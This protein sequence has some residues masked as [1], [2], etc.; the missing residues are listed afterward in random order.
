MTTRP[1]MGEREIDDFLLW[2]RVERG[3]S[4]STITSYHRDLMKYLVWLNQEGTSV[5]AVE[6]ESII[7]YLRRLQAEG[8]AASTVTRAMVAI[9]AFHRFLTM[10]SIRADDPTSDVELPRVPRGLPKPI[11]EKEVIRLLAAIEGHEPAARRDR[12]ILELLYGTGARISEVVTLSIS[13]VDIQESLLKVF[14]KGKKERI[15]P[16][17]RCALEAINEWLR[18]EGRGAFE[19][20]LWACRADSEA[21][22]L[23]RRGHRLSRQGGWGIVKKYGSRVGLGSGLSPHTLRHSCATHM[24]EHGADIRTVQELLGHASISTTQIYTQVSR[25]QLIDAYRSAHPRALI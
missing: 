16:L 3:R 22:F 7:S 17:G 10:E 20:D 11:S 23:N 25:D 14:G 5:V 1:V 15:V 13:D 18:P 9:R 12:A 2:L 19:P 21:L 4:G 8:L 24:L 6:E